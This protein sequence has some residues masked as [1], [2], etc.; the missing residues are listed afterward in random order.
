[1]KHSQTF[2]FVRLS[3]KCETRSDHKTEFLLENNY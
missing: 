2:D 3:M 1:M